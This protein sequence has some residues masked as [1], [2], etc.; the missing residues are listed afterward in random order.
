MRPEEGKV[1]KSYTQVRVTILH[2][3]FT[4]VKIKTVIKLII[5]VNAHLKELLLTGLG[6]QLC[7]TS[8]F[9][10]IFHDVFIYLFRTDKK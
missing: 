6:S 4:Q 3:N 7:V 1:P 10:H 5:K 9:V 2:C 8:G